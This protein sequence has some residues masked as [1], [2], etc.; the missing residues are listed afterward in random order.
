MGKISLVSALA[1]TIGV[2]SGLWMIIAWAL[3]KSGVVALTVPAWAAFIGMPLYFA[4]RGGKA[5]PK[6]LGLTFTGLLGGALMSMVMFGIGDLLSAIPEPLPIA[7][8]VGVG[9]WIVVSYS[10]LSW[11]PYVPAGFAGASASFAFGAAPYKWDLLIALVIAMFSGAFLGF[12]A[13]VWG[14]AWAK[15]AVNE[16][17][18]K[19][20]QLQV[21]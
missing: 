3:D 19:E 15:E 2:V 16:A 4:S 21:E 10:R 17:V 11:I 6:G 12:V 5:G 18:A 1:I 20:A 8:G 13:D 7:I 9:S 14:H